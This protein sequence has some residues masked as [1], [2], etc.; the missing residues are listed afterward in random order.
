MPVTYATYMADASVCRAVGI[1]LVGWMHFVNVLLHVLNFVLLF[2]LLRTLCRVGS[3]SAAW[4]LALAMIWAVHPLRVE[5]VAW[6]AGRKELLWSLFSLAGLM[7]WASSVRRREESVVSW[8]PMLFAYLCCLFACLSKPT[9]M[10][11]PLLALLVEGMVGKKPWT[12]GLRMF[13]RYIPLVLFAAATAAIAAYSQTHVAGQSATSLYA[14]PFLTRLV[15]AVSSVGFYL[16]AAVWPFGLH[17]DCRAVEGFWPLGACW[18]IL[19]LVIFAGA[20]MVVWG[21]A[22]D[23]Q[24]MGKGSFAHG[25]I[26]FA[27]GWFLVSVFPTL[28]LLGSFGFEAHADRFAYVPSMMFAFLLAGCQTERFQACARKVAMLT[29]AVLAMVTFRQL[30]FWRDDGVAHMRAL[31]CDPDHPRAMVHV[32][33]SLCSRSHDFDGGISL[34]R[35]ALSLSRTVPAG[36]FDVADT[37]AR[38]AYALASRGRAADFDEI[39]ALG[40]DVLGDF[41]LDRRGMMLDALGTAMMKRGEAG[42]AAALFQ[43]S[44]DAPAR[45]WPK[46]STKQKL[47]ACRKGEM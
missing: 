8:C 11:F 24:P 38:L 23:S 47:V 37:K 43:A 7:L 42:K 9:A 36:G 34:Y 20:L 26:L 30:G 44:L 29:V 16:K 5:P 14:A 31:A 15:N 6:I 10:C 39:L 35:K 41:S 22:K 13:M 3:G 1:P 2:C 18:N 27:L 12:G 46:A 17:I 4:A 40:A 19:A 32:A 21:R 45:F 28:G 25:Q 33:D